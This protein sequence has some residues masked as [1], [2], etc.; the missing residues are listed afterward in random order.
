MDYEQ[1]RPGGIRLIPPQEHADLLERDYE[2]KREI[3][4]GERLS[5]GE[6]LDALRS[7][8]AEINSLNPD[9]STSEPGPA[10]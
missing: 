9:G 3:I 1:L 4:F 8:E 6:V 10:S 5:F 2:S 7:L